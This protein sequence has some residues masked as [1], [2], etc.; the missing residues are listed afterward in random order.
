M[1]RFF[2]LCL[3]PALAACTPEPIVKLSWELDRLI[4]ESGAQAAVAFRTLDG[5]D[6][7]LINPDV[8]FHAASTMKVPVMIELFRQD[9]DGMLSLEDEIT[10]AKEFHSIIDGSPYMLS[11]DDDS[12]TEIYDA[13]GEQRTLRELSEVMITISSNLA[14]N[15][16]IERLGAANIQATVDGLGASGMQVLRGVED[17]KAYR[18][19]KNNTTTARG[20]LVLLQKLGRL[21]AVDPESSR[22]MIAILK[23]QQFGEAIPAGLPDGVEVAHKTGQITRIHHDAA[24]VY[25]PRPFVLV[26]L[27]RGLEDETKSAALMAE[28]TRRV[29]EYA[30]R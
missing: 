12:D 27:V 19:G 5:R 10:V 22:Q 16:L 9:R 14:A 30:D 29:W 13:L 26:L 20:L 7:V 25:G 11:V 6:E 4:E 24:I 28:M 18:A 23:R 15:L 8:S 17:I 21:E 2:L 3:F 1:K